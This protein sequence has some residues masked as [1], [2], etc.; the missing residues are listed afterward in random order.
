[1][2]KRTDIGNAICTK[3]KDLFDLSHE[4][5]SNASATIEGQNVNTLTKRIILFHYIRAI[6]LHIAIVKLC[7]EG[8][9]NEAFVILRSLLNLLINLKWITSE[10]SQSRMQRFADFDIVGKKLSIDRAINKGTISKEKA[11]E[12]FPDLNRKFEVVKMKY[13]LKS[14]RDF[15][16][17][18]GVNI[19]NMAQEIGFEDYY[20]DIY[21]QLSDIEHT[22]HRSV[23]HYI[24]DS[25]HG[26]ISVRIGGID[27]NTDHAIL[28]SFDLFLRVKAIA[29]VT[30]KLNID[31]LK[32]ENQKI[33]D[34][35][36]KYWT[37]ELI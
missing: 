8:H 14:N 3:Y 17:W 11:A 32:K 35:R 20:L 21:S 18:S 15:K 1:M 4:M 28:T 24:D 37:T 27:E 7:M 31:I 12:R 6:N 26:N 19:F 13:N 34:L 29:Y 16:N 2:C 25:V 9:A 23:R 33:E 5:I 36:A 22:G 30:F 10:D